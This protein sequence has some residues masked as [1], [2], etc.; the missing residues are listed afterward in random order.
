[1]TDRNTSAGI[2]AAIAAVFSGFLLFLKRRERDDE[3]EI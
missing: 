1:M 3:E 2:G